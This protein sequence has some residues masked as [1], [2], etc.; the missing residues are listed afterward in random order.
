MKFT[1]LPSRRQKPMPPNG[2]SATFGKPFGLE[3]YRKDKKCLPCKV[4][5]RSNP[6]PQVR[7][8]NRVWVHTLTIRHRS[9]GRRITTDADI[10]GSMTELLRRIRQHGKTT[11]ATPPLA[12]AAPDLASCQ[13]RQESTH[14][15]RAQA[16]ARQGAPEIRGLT[17][18]PGL[19]SA[20]V[21]SASS[22]LCATTGDWS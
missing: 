3:L 21:R 2:R 12:P 11:A 4:C 20:A 19:W 15:C 13:N 8:L 17:T 9:R 10:R 18:V 14:H 16:P 1:T 6:R 22:A 5:Q 7:P